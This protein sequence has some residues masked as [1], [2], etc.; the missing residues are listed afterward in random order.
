MSKIFFP[1]ENW[2]SVDQLLRD[3][4]G[5]S[6][7]IKELDLNA[8]HLKEIQS[9]LN[10]ILQKAS[11]SLQKDLEWTSVRETISYQ[12]KVKFSLTP[13][14][15]NRA[16]ECEVFM[17]LEEVGVE[18]KLLGKSV[19]SQPSKVS[20]NLK[21]L[22]PNHPLAP[23]S[24]KNFTGTMAI[25]NVFKPPVKIPLL[26]GSEN[27]SALAENILQ[28]LRSLNYNLAKDLSVHLKN[29][30]IEDK[31]LKITLRS[32]GDYLEHFN[33]FPSKFKDIIVQQIKD[34]GPKFDP[35]MELAYLQSMK[36][37]FDEKRHHYVPEAFQIQIDALF[38]E[39][40]KEVLN[41]IIEQIQVQQ[42]LVRERFK[43]FS[44]LDADKKRMVQLQ[45]DVEAQKKKGASEETLRGKR[46]EVKKIF[47]KVQKVLNEYESCK[48]IIL[49]QELLLSL[50]SN[51]EDLADLMPSK[52]LHEVKTKLQANHISA[53]KDIE[54][55]T[56]NLGMHA[57]HLLVQ[58]AIYSEVEPDINQVVILENI[59]NYDK[60][61]LGSILTI[62]PSLAEKF[63][64]GDVNSTQVLQTVWNGDL[65]EREKQKFLQFQQSNIDPKNN[66][67]HRFSEQLEQFIQVSDLHK[68][69]LN[70]MVSHLEVEMANLKAV[71]SFA[72]EK[73]KLNTDFK[74]HLRYFEQLFIYPYSD[75]LEKCQHEKAEEIDRQ[76][77]K[78]KNMLKVNLDIKY[79]TLEEKALLSMFKQIHQQ[80]QN[81]NLFMAGVFTQQIK[82][83]LHQLTNFK[84]KISNDLLKK[85]LS[86][87]TVFM[88]GSSR[89]RQLSK[90]SKTL[91]NEDL[92]RIKQNRASLTT[93]S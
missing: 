52:K 22:K 18:G 78:I 24:N 42:N 73:G 92:D 3:D 74:N 87:Y 38:N 48:G 32:I 62:M 13:N 26:K 49:M 93:S 88:M 91:S 44:G 19:Q 85:I 16:I 39:R 41:E 46:L 21:K 57:D 7:S 37:V 29:E 1:L 9:E 27:G 30:F 45:Q 64:D 61:D 80:L 75:F 25:E 89:T 54:I 71:I 8:D 2:N 23:F 63:K 83:F 14:G 34:I 17:G 56:R 86:T 11:S 59:G 12:H 40:F 77:G 36:A 55:L 10:S 68:G 6:L 79:S 84:T 5:L 60:K 28:L 20:F 82:R 66:V 51:D 31:S 76:H 53:S 72:A 33:E 15:R 50:I 58:H 47:K 70:S 4:V 67:V 35:E 90:Q 65:P 69:D 81:E 43:A